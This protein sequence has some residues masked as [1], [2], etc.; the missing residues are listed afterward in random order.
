MNNVAE[1][2]HFFIFYEIWIATYLIA[3]YTVTRNINAIF[4]RKKVIICSH[5]CHF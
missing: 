2:K 4:Q 1:K 5:N 3:C